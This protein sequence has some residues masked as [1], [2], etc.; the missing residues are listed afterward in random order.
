[1]PHLLSGPLP[2]DVA[3]LHTSAP[4]D[5]TVSLGT[6]VNI[7][8]AAIEAVRRRGGLVLA[9]LNRHMPH[10]YGDGVLP[11][12]EIDYAIEVDAALS[13][14]PQREP[15]EVARLIGANVAHLVPEGA[16]LQLGIGAVPDAVLSALRG[17][18]SLPECNAPTTKSACPP[19]PE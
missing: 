8:P 4:R 1:M 9:Q 17:R 13:V 18:R 5:D 3:L 16:T 11:L 19:K 6:E 2:P 12:D 15:D 14:P 7:L 10:T